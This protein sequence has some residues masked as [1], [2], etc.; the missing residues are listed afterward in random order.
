[1]LG[2][3]LWEGVVSLSPGNPTPPPHFSMLVKGVLAKVAQPQRPPPPRPSW[4]VHV[5]GRRGEGVWGA[6]GG[7]DGRE[8]EC[9]LG[10]G[11]GNSAVCWALIKLRKAYESQLTC[12]ALLALSDPASK[13]LCQ[14]GPG[15]LE[16]DHAQGISAPT[17]WHRTGKC[18]SLAEE[19]RAAR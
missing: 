16:L 8:D 10:Q 15:G 19:S 7:Q 6:G 13:P 14:G 11:T 12:S 9:L 2:V 4:R 17:G 1:M 5:C 18:V 3:E